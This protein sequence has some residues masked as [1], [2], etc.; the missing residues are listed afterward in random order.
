MTDAAE[1]VLDEAMKLPD[2]ERRALGLWLLDSVGDEAPEEIERVWIEEAR[3]R[4]DEIRAGRADVEPWAV[5]K[6]RIFARDR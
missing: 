2:G 1:K 6:A 5:A 4:L 3:R